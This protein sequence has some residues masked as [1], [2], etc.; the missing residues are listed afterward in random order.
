MTLWKSLEDIKRDK[1]YTV[2]LPNAYNG[3]FSL[4]WFCLVTLAMYVPGSPFMYKH[5]LRQRNK[6]YAKAKSA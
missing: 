3:A 2:E 1:P 5:M 6:V 4:Y